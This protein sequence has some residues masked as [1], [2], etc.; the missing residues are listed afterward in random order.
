[1]KQQQNCTT[2]FWSV[3]MT[4]VIQKVSSN[5][6]LKKKQVYQTQFCEE[7]TMKF[8]KNAGKVT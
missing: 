6:L 7:V 2:Y 1:M 4:M 5:G 8:E 3:A